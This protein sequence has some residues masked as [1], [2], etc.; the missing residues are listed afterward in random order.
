MNSIPQAASEELA[1]APHA[2]WPLAERPD[3]R[4]FTY[5]ASGALL[6]LVSAA[7]IVYV[8]YHGWLAQDIAKDWAYAGIGFPFLAYAAGVFLFSYGWERRDAARALRLTAIVCVLSVVAIFAAII[9]LAALAKSKGSAASAAGSAAA[10]TDS[11]DGSIL[12]VPLVRAVGSILGDELEARAYSDGAG[13]SVDDA[14]PLEERPFTIRCLR[15]GSRFAP[16][17]PRAVCPDCGEAALPT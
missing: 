15:C 17:P 13:G 6:A 9:I 12:P 1:A 2:G 7:L 11:E 5:L 14:A 3:E 8:V 10:S 4:P 16:V